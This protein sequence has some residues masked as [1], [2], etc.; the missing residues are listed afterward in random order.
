MVIEQAPNK[1][2][3]LAGADRAK[4]SGVLCPGAPRLTDGLGDL[5]PLGLSPAEMW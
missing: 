1:R 2:V 3:K 5:K 4:G